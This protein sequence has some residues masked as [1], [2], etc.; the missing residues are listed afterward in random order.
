VLTFA[1]EGIYT[2]T[3]T[4][5]DND[6][7]KNQTEQKISVGK[8]VHIEFQGFKDSY[9]IGDPIDIKLKVNVK[10]D[11]FNRVDLW[12]AIQLPSGLLFKTPIG[13]NSFKPTPQAFKTSLETVDDGVYGV[14]N[15][16]LVPGLGGSYTFLAAFFE[17][18]KNPMDYLDNLSAIQRSEFVTRT[19]ILASE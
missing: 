2:V 15:F 8:L 1:Q 4:V 12:L 19:T 17:E 11:R 13:I 3:L 6:G 10:V 14:V 9:K 16:E 18:G 7:L 5:I